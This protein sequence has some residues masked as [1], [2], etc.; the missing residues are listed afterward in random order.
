MCRAPLENGVPPMEV[1]VDGLNLRMAEAAEA[2]HENIVRLMLFQGASDLNMGLTSAA[3][4][5]HE[6]IVKKKAIINLKNTDNKCFMWAVTRALS[7]VALNDP[8]LRTA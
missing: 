5:G 4:G 2:G 7:Q 8:S 3:A 6:S 1:S